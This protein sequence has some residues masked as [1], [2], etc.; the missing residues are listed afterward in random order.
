MDVQ[1]AGVWHVTYDTYSTRRV[2]EDFSTDLGLTYG[3]KLSGDVGM[4]VGVDW[5]SRTTYPFY[6]NA[7]AGIAEGALS[8]GSPGIGL[9]IFNVGTKKGDA[10]AGIGG[11]NQN[12]IH[13]ELG[14]TFGDVRLHA[15]YYNGND[16]ILVSSTGA[17]EDDGFM[18][19]FDYG[20]EPVEDADG[21][22]NK[23]ILAGDWAS[24][25][26][27]LGGGGVGLFWFFTRNASLLM[28]PV[29]FNDQGL[30]GKMKW[31]T[32]LDVNF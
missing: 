5:L 12:V 32:Q 15:G 30:N 22:Y 7:K 3:F 27:L 21:S 2:G 14:K 1:P 23:Y 20:F 9:G 13:V 29:W 18:I 25:D 28:G 16:N 19:A 8:S 31:T 6:F 4:E 24:G 26:N 10:A 17:K 11:T